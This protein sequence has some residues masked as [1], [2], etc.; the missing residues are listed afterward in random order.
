MLLEEMRKLL[1]PFLGWPKAYQRIVGHSKG[2][3][4]VNIHKKKL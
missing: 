1:H 2:V 3:D 4:T